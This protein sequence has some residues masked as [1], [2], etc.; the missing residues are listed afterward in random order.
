MYYYKATDIIFLRDGVDKR[1]YDTLNDDGYTIG[2][3]LY[4]VH[5]DYIDQDGEFM[6]VELQ[7]SFMIEDLST[8]NIMI[9]KILNYERLYCYIEGEKKRRWWL[10]K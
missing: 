7:S 8:I 5:F 4:D 2:G 9:C 6:R 1:G 10:W 3:D